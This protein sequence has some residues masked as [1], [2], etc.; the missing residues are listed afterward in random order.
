M[1]IT[2]TRCAGT[3]LTTFVTRSLE[4][5]PEGAWTATMVQ[6]ATLNALKDISDAT[7]AVNV[8]TVP[9]LLLAN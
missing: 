9:V 6:G 2:V 3:V 1:A 5:A 7:A 4:T 8:A